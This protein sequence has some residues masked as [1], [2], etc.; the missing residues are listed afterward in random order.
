MENLV[1]AVFVATPDG[2]TIAGYYTISAYA[3]VAGD[4]P[5]EVLKQLKSKHPLLPATLI[6]RLARALAYKGQHLG[7]LLL[8]SVLERALSHSREVASLAVVVDAKDRRAISFYAQFGFIQFP[9][10]P[11]RM[12]LPMK[13]VADLFSCADPQ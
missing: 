5:D 7:E 13:T 10:H 1:A 4:L 11:N 3:I 9:D 6:G 2:K 12:F 8:M